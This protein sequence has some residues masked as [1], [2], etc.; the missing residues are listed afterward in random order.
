MLLFN[1]LILFL[2]GIFPAAL[3][4]VQRDPL[5]SLHA[6]WGF[7]NDRSLNVILKVSAQEW[8]TNIWLVFAVKCT[9][10]MYVL[11]AILF[12]S[13]FGTTPQAMRRYRS[14][15][16]YILE[17]IGLQKKKPSMAAS[18][19]MFSSNPQVPHRQPVRRETLSFLDSSNN[20]GGHFTVSVLS[21]SLIEGE[22]PKPITGTIEQGGGCKNVSF[23]SSA[24][25]AIPEETSS[26]NVHR[27]SMPDEVRNSG[28]ND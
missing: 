13:I 2:I 8:G 26:D 17:K 4:A 7:V 21:A 14:A 11:D 9:E 15:T 25:V 22:G 12:F 6:S 23:L 3:I 20:S 10:W 1:V 5:T 16:L 24:Q 27:S 19:I 28:E 18:D